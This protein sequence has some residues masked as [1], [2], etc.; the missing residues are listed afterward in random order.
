MDAIVAST[1]LHHVADLAVVLDQ[2][3]ALLVP[4]GRVVIVEWAHERFDEATARWCFARL[5]EPGEHQARLPEPGEDHA[6]LQHR[7][8]EWRESGQPWDDYLRSWAQAEG[9][10]SGQ[11]ILAALGERFDSETVTYGPYFFA[12]LADTSEADEQAAIDGGL[13]QANRIQYA[14]RPRLRP[15]SVDQVAELV[16]AR[17]A[18]LGIRAVQV[19]G[20][21]AGRKEQPVGDLRIGQALAGE[22]HD[23]ALLRGELRERARHR[24]GGLR[25][26]AAGAKF[27]LGAPGPQCGAQAAERLERRCQDLLGLVDPALPAQPFS[28]V[29]LELGPFERPGLSGRTGQGDREVIPAVRRLGEQA[30]GAGRKLLQPRARGRIHPGNGAFD[31]GPGLLGTL[32]ADGGGRVVGDA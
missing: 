20:D 2:V 15:G 21:S 32:R 29:Q 9:L 16:A 8:A 24:M 12:D 17:Y 13:I 18:E 11:D 30:A 4:D 19:R 28:V 6:W 1:S 7:R 25:G 14:G 5:P 31:H 3:K 26:H 22:D 23:L 27:G 10:H